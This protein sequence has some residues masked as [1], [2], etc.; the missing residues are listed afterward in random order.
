[1]GHPGE[2]GNLLLG[3]HGKS[4]PCAAGKLLRG[5]SSVFSEALVLPF[6]Q[7]CCALPSLMSLSALSQRV[8]GHWG[9]AQPFLPG[10]Q[11]CD[12]TAR[13]C[14][15]LPKPPLPSCT[16]QEGRDGPPGTLL[17][18]MLCPCLSSTP[19]SLR[20]DAR[21]G[22]SAATI[23]CSPQSSRSSGSPMDKSWIPD[24]FAQDTESVTTFFFFLS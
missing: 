12:P 13:P 14:W 9:S 24:T 22:R 6:R 11:Q 20:A 23:P 16:A 18:L 3:V 8:Q 2:V 21:H 7:S 15:M 5:E 4:Q 19:A 1:M 10:S 17:P